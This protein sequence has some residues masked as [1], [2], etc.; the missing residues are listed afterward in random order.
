M[1][2]CKCNSLYTLP[3]IVEQVRYIAHFRAAQDFHLQTPERMS[4]EQVPD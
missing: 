3:Y 4:E 2:Q 1:L